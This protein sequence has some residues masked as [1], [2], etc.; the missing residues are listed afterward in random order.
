MHVHQRRAFESADYDGWRI[1]LH[2]IVSPAVSVRAARV[3]RR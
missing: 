3:V 2:P 1:G